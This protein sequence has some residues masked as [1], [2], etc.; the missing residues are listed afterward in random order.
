MTPQLVLG[1]FLMIVGALMTLDRLELLDA[2][3]VLRFWPLLFIGFGLTLLTARRDAAGRFW[4]G[5]WLFV[6][7]W[8]LLNSLG[9][10]RVGFWELFWPLLLILLGTG[11][12]LQTIR[13]NR[14]Y[15]SR[16]DVADSSNLF[17]MLAETKRAFANQPFEGGTM[18]AI[19]GG[20]SLD[21]RQA[22]MAPGQEAVIDVI[23]VMAGHEIAVPPNWTVVSEL[24]PIAGGVEDKRLPPLPD[25]AASSAPPPR[26]VLKGFLVMAGL[27]IKS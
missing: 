4:G 15:A 10:L 23:G 11:L 24:V 17:A 8:L 18:T 25:A 3:R 21:L 6:G 20:C 16:P 1:A 14:G 13:R 12:V 7:S 2:G 9:V 19:L 22:T 26:L 27:T 5:A